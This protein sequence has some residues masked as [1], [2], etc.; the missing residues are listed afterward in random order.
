MCE[1]LALAR[2]C[3]AGERRRHRPACGRAELLAAQIMSALLA[4]RN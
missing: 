3:R 1:L 2:T 4:T